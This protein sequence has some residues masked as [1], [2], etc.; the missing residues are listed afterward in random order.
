MVLIRRSTKWSVPSGVAKRKGDS[1][2]SIGV[3]KCAGTT[4]PV[5]GRLSH[6]GT[7]D[8]LMKILRK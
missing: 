1:F 5:P 4:L 3:T 7:W 2:M 8:A 6:D